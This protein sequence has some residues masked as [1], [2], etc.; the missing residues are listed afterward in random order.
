MFKTI[1]EIF[2]GN[3]EVTNKL[4]PIPTPP[5]TVNAP[6]DDDVDTV[7]EEITVSFVNVLIP[8]KDCA[9]VVT[10]PVEPVPA[11]GILNVCEAPTNIEESS[12]S[13][14]LKSLSA[15]S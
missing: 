11:I 15:V 5:V 9:E 10:K 13:A 6:E 8:A 12:R 7:L 1:P 2:E 4:P 14:S 3:E